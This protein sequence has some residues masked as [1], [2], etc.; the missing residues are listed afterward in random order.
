MRGP[1]L[2][3]EYR[4]TEFTRHAQWQCCHHRHFVKDSRNYMQT[5]QKVQS[6]WSLR[7]QNYLNYPTFTEYFVITKICRSSCA[8]PFCGAPVQPNMLNM[9]KSASAQVYYDK[10][11]AVKNVSE[12]ETTCFVSTGTQGLNSINQSTR[13]VSADRRP[14]HALDCIQL[15]SELCRSD[16]VAL[17]WS[18]LAFIAIFIWCRCFKK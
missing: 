4:P 8:A 6:N 1:S 5:E 7:Q 18:A 2:I 9:P 17:S 14:G 12:C 11:L 3:Y 15:Y 16:T 10:R 13:P